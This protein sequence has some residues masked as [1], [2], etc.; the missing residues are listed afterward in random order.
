MNLNLNSSEQ[1]IFALFFVLSDRFQAQ[2]WCGNFLPHRPL[3]EINELTTVKVFVPFSLA[4]SERRC[5]FAAS[6]R[7]NKEIHFHAS[8]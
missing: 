3:I 4:A 6:G 8:K 2:Q 7:Y 1:S 5:C